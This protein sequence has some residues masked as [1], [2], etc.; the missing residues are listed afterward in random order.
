M[1]SAGPEGKPS[2]A[3]VRPSLLWPGQ[4][5]ER[6]AAWDRWAFAAA[7]V[8]AATIRW[9][10]RDV[11]PYTAEAAH[12]A[13]SRNLWQGVDNLGSLF[14]DVVVDDFSWFFWQ[15][16]LLCLLYAPA[17]LFGFEAY[18]VAHILVASTVPVLAAVLLRQLGTRPAFAYAAAAVLAVHPVLVPW[19]VLVLPD[20]TVAVFTLLGLLAAHDGRPFATAGLLLAGAWVKEIGF[21]TAA[22]L[23]VLAMWREADGT[24]ASLWPI[25]LGPF[26]TLLLPV[27]FLSFVPL[28]VSLALP[29][30]AMPGFRLGGD[31]AE[32]LQR[33]FLL[34]WL[35]PAPLLGLLV[36]RVRRLCL[37]ALAWPAFFLTFTLATGKAIEIWY[38]VVP[39]TLI[40]CAAAAT[41]SAAPRVGPAQQRLAPTTAGIVLLTL[42]LV[43]V[44]VPQ[45]HPANVAIATPL[46]GA[47]QWNLQEALDAEQ[48]RDDDLHALLGGIPAD[49]EGTWLALDMDYSL[50]MH[51]LASRAGFVFKDYTMEGD[52]S[53]EAIRW[54][55]N[56]VEQR[57]DATILAHQS[58][59]LNEALRE[60]YAPCAATLGQYTVIQPQGCQ[61]YGDRLIEAYR[62]RRVGKG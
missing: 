30:G 15:R 45:A 1:T 27:V 47:G 35:A 53:D 44:S 18:R 6:L 38:N 51:P 12:Y 24:R 34:L 55:A 20:T 57:A 5:R 25:R 39:A 46:T 58:T 14:P 43:Q 7:F 9:T 29:Y 22:A 13:M 31:L 37:V 61:S 16:P 60:A 52:A 8:L 59:S 21:V 11:H 41:L 50:V 62:E 19:G 49:R 3:P 42:L 54:W 2:R 48:A 32:S 17:A 40:L 23:L 28:A 56:A 4:V 26:A 36:P 33:Q 10:I